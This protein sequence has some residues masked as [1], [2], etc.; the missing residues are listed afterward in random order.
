MWS[1]VVGKDA[2]KVAAILKKQAFRR[3]ALRKSK[4]ESHCWL[5]LYAW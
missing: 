3:E 1:L 2:D 5:V 4:A